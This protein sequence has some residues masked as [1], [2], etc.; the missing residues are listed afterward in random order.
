VNASGVV[1]LVAEAARGERLTKDAFVKPAFGYF[2]AKQRLAKRIVG[3]LPPHN[4]WVEA[5]CGSM[6]VTLNKKP[7]PIE[8]VNDLDGDVVNAFTVLRDQSEALIRAIALTPYARDEFELARANP[9]PSDPIERARQ[10]LV[11]A[12]MTVNGT[13]GSAHNSGF[14]FSN[15]YVRGGREARVNRWYQLPERL[16]GVVE[17]L[18]DLRIENKDARVIIRQ[19]AQRPAT[20]VYL[21]PPYLTDRKHVYAKDANDEQF[22]TELLEACVES[23]CMILVSGYKNALYAKYLSKRNGWSSSA[24]EVTTRGTGGVDAERTELLWTNAAFR[25]ANS[26]GQVPV[27]LT[28]VEANGKKLNPERRPSRRARRK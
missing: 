26:T 10:F 28:K 3:M 23:E 22:H 17:R 20:L 14:S 2:G 19:F 7:V 18:R 27:K 5:F 13:A 25:R 4:A 15:S 16:S 24:I 9:V 12:M 6:V 21:D 1:E 8:V 11:A